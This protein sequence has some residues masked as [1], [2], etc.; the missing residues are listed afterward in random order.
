MPELRQTRLG[1]LK[2]HDDYWWFSASYIILALVLSMWISI[3]WLVALV[4][5]HA[6]I[7]WKSLKMNGIHDNLGMHVFWHLKLDIMLVVFALWLGVYLES[8][9]GVLGLGHAA[10][11]GAQV[12]SRALAL[13]QT[14]RGVAMSAD[15]AALA[16][17]AI[18]NKAKG[19]KEGD[20][21]ERSSLLPWRGRWG[22]GDRL[23]IGFIV[24]LILSILLAPFITDQAVTDVIAALANDL[25]PW[26]PGKE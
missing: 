15:E 7:E 20:Q 6:L 12:G 26:P 1:W 3:F 17:K 16:A 21:E 8:I 11:A 25:H 24:L 9:L 10:R 4:G 13:Q 2:S 23:T 18:W 22:W 19:K 14:I 5:L